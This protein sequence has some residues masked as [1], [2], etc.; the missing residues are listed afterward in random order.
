MKSISQN[1]RNQIVAAL[2]DAYDDTLKEQDVH[3]DRIE[4]MEECGNK[5]YLKIL[6]SI[7]WDGIAK[8]MAGECWP[9]SDEERKNL[10]DQEHDEAPSRIQIN[11]I[12][13]EDIRFHTYFLGEVTDH[14]KRIKAM[15]K[16]YEVLGSHPED[17]FANLLCRLWVNQ[18]ICI[19]LA[20]EQQ[21]AGNEEICNDLLQVANA[22]QEVFD[23][24]AK[25][26]EKLAPKKNKSIQAL[27]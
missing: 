22:A 4:V 10:L 13:D 8:S 18:D 5:D 24:F 23:V 1:D 16:F 21:E 26:P 17:A 12:E 27:Q 19:Q 11:Q 9:P 20:N 15:A 7:G 3:R 2:K 25:D 14:C 6:P